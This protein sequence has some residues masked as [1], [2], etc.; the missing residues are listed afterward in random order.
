M[1]RYLK[2]LTSVT[3]S[4]KCRF[5]CQLEPLISFPQRGKRQITFLFG[6]SKLYSE[7][8]GKMS[9][10]AE[11]AQSRPTQFLDISRRHY[12]VT[13]ALLGFYLT[14]SHTLSHKHPII[15]VLNKI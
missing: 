4:E 11:G 6:K 7:N 15:Q 14:L 9:R 5:K 8:V 1:E 13:T 12:H 3:F 2:H 10:P